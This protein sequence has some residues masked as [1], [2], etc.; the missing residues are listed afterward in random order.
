M[1]SLR[2][3]GE[4]MAPSYL[5]QE[6]CC[7]TLAQ[8]IREGVTHSPGDRCPDGQVGGWVVKAVGS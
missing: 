2:A 4:C 8:N 1:R 3:V 5:L 7:S 6:L